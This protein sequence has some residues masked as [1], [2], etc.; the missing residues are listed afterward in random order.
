MQRLA[1]VRTGET[2]TEQ[3]K[4]ELDTEKEAIAMLTRGIEVC[5][6]KDEG[7]RLLLEHILDDEEDHANWLETQLELVRQVGEQLYLSTPVRS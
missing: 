2:V 3:L 6:T 1:T 4:A 7:S 5:R